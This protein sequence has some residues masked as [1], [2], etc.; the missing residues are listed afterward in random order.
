[1]THTTAGF[2]NRYTGVAEQADHAAANFLYCVLLEEGNANKKP[3]GL[4]RVL[5]L[6]LLF[7][8]FV[9]VIVVTVLLVFTTAAATAFAVV[10]LGL[11]AE[12]VGT[13][14]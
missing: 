11:I 2:V 7:E 9:L 8:V 3:A 1:M 14:K 12:F 10:I 4:L 6:S 13:R 5:C